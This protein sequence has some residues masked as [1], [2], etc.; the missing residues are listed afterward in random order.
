MHA[1][2]LAHRQRLENKLQFANHMELTG[3]ELN[4]N[5][6]SLSGIMCM[7]EHPHNQHYDMQSTTI[8]DKPGV[9]KESGQVNS[10]KASVNEFNVTTFHRQIKAH[11]TPQH[12]SFTLPLQM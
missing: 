6:P 3:T 4:Q 7:P 12:T 11:S 5:N 2:T 1:H 9:E 8:L 10:A